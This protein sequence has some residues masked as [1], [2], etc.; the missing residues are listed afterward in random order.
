MDELRIDLNCDLGESSGDGVPGDLVL[1][2]HI[3][4]ANIAC[5]FHAGSPSVMRQTVRNALSKGLCLGAHPGFFDREGFGRR[6]LALTGDE[7]FE[8]VLYQLGAL[9][10]I[11]SAEGGKLSHLKPH[12]ALYNMAA[13]DLT[14]A[15]SISEAVYA[16]DP[17]LI[18]YGLA[19]SQLIQAARKLGLKTAQEAFADRNYLADGN[20]VPRTDPQALVTS[21]REAAT[22]VVRMIKENKVKSQSGDDIDLYADTIC[23]HGDTPDAVNF[24]RE[25][26]VVLKD[27]KI[28]I[29]GVGAK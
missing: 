12:G 19:G 17:E 2:D 21:P 22:R 6:R 23:V 1:M 7:V 26:S 16:F 4:S 3:T 20:L 5:G 9:G 29:K 24:L 11:V 14:L 18:L 28:L 8:I 27:E 25:L 13:V 10:A 15:Q